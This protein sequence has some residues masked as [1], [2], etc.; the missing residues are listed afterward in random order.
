MT[1]K[2]IHELSEADQKRLARVVMRKQGALSLRVASVFFVL[3]VGIPLVNAF[4]PRLANTPIAGFTVT[5]FFLGVVIYP[6]TIGLS[7]YF[8][9]KSDEIEASCTDWRKALA[10]EETR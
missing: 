10:E 7:V 4:L 8:V 6:I 2:A 9:R 5:W 1:D 3:I